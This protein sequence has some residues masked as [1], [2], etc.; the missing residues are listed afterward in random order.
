MSK[1]ESLTFKNF[2]FGGKTNAAPEIN[3]STSCD[4]GSEGEGLGAIGA[5]V[6]LQDAARRK[7]CLC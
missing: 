2:R 5:F 1:I 6:R 7:G 4:H 3:I